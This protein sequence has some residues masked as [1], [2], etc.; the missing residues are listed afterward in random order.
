MIDLHIL[1]FSIQ[2]YVSFR[3]KQRKTSGRRQ[4]FTDESDSGNTTNDSFVSDGGDVV[5]HAA[6]RK[7]AKRIRWTEQE[8]NEWVLL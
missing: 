2:Y 4:L 1:I 8:T 6:R 7:K 5:R 3:E